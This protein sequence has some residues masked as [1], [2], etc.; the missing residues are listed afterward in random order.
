MF[1]AYIV[2]TLLTAAANAF[3]ATVDFRRPQ[4]LLDNITKWG[5]LT[6]C[7]R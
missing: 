2:V 6:V 7:L 5:G 3:A 4:W 1:A